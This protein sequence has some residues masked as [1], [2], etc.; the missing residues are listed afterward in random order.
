MTEFTLSFI[1]FSHFYKP[2]MNLFFRQ[3][4]NDS[5]HV[6]VKVSTNYAT[7]NIFMHT[8]HCIWNITLNEML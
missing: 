1:F 5:V 2:Q 3:Q 4:V 7:R 6:L 8:P